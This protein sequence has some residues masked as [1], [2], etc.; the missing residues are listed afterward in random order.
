ML[1]AAAA[2]LA[3]H[4]QSAAS[5]ASLGTARSLLADA[6]GRCGAEGVERLEGL[7]VPNGS[8]GTRQDTLQRHGALAR[9]HAQRRCGGFGGFGGKQT[10][11]GTAR[12]QGYMLRGFGG[13]EGANTA[14]EPY[15]PAWRRGEGFGACGGLEGAKRQLP[16]RT[17]H[18]SWLFWPC[19]AARVQPAQ[20][21]WAQRQAF[22]HMRGAA[23][24]GLARS[25]GLRVPNG[26]FGT[27]QNTFW[28]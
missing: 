5:A 9:L 28:R 14:S 20:Q 21:A 7:R 3:L 1:G 10:I 11:A 19:T 8:F 18:L 22:R 26:S 15:T 24:V 16:N 2:L 17:K 25:E 12:W 4:G 23:A 13:F 27:R 6:W